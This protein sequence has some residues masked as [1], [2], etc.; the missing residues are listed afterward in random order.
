MKFK[1]RLM[2]ILLSSFLISSLLVSCGNKTNNYNEDIY[3]IYQ[4]AKD[5]G[6]Q[7]TYEEWLESIKGEK[8]E[9]GEKGDKGEIGNPGKDGKN[10]EDGKTPVIA[11]GEN[12][13]WFIDGV[14]T[15]VNANGKQGV[16]GI[17]GKNGT[18]I[19]TGDGLELSAKFGNNGDS[20]INTSTWD[21][22]VKENNNW[23]KVDNIKGSDGK[24]GVDGSDGVSGKDGV[25]GKDGTV[26][27]TGNYDPLDEYGKNG[28]FFLNTYSFDIFL[29]N[30]DKWDKLGNI[31]GSD[32]KDGVDGKDGID[33]KDGNDAETYNISYT[34]TFDALGGKLTN[35]QNVIIAK[36]GETIN[37]PIAEKDN[38]IFKGW[39]TGFGIND[40]KFTNAT[41][42]TSNITLYACWEAI[43]EYTVYFN[44]N[45]G[46]N[47][48]PIN[49]QNN[50]EVDKLPAPTKVDYTFY[51]WYYD[52]GLSNRV[53][54]PFIIEK[55]IE[56]YAKWIDAYYFL[57]FDT[58]GGEIIDNKSF[59]AGTEIIDLPTPSKTYYVFDG[60]YM[61][62]GYS[63][64]VTLPFE[65]HENI[66]IYAK[67]TTTDSVVSFNTN[68]GDNLSDKIVQTGTY[69]LETNM[70]TPIRKNY[71]FDGWYADVSL[72]TKISYPYVVGEDITLYAKWTDNYSGY[73]KISSYS[74][75]CS[76]NKMNGK[77]VLTQ[78]IDCNGYAINQ[79]GSETNPFSGVFD[80]NGYTISNY[81]LNISN[82]VKVDG[83]YLGDYGLFSK[84]NGT[85]INLKIDT[86]LTINCIG[87]INSSF[88]VG[89]I[90]GE[91]TGTISSCGFYG[92]IKATKAQKGGYLH[93]G[94]IVG[95]NTS[96]GF[97]NNCIFGGRLEGGVGDDGIIYS[98]KSQVGGISGSNQGTITLCVNAGSLFS[99]NPYCSG[100][101]TGKQ[102]YVS[103]IANGG[104]INNCLVLISIDGTNI[105]YGSDIGYGSTVSNCYKYENILLVGST[106]QE[107]A[108][109][110]SY[111]KINSKSFYTN[112]LYFNTSIWN[113]NNLDYSCGFYIDLI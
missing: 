54:Y 103:G 6:Y 1:V 5:D 14:D 45:G 107:K 66:T 8:G 96:S 50:I 51:G 57:S 39:Y 55:D 40:G 18:S 52:E 47:L 83:V 65:I 79:I 10:G 25:D 108:T 38:F 15:Q 7:G 89:S 93:V 102:T 13:N 48:E 104:I 80:G 34:I 110:V 100:A 4:L 63:T 58:H 11:I 75:L 26:W 105:S 9:K 61:D 101:V 12:G 20:Y 29:K 106:K 91:N 35:S 22:Y 94:G 99:K 23:K 59:I 21:F 44:T 98:A 95:K 74:Q 37:L 70:P 17:P 3:R 28:D 82:A 77:Y 84:N 87:E 33:G 31:K 73:T 90:V 32:G 71:T 97:I 41:P 53:T 24:D 49:Y 86:V 27:S 92:E 56:V 19:Y 16:M 46:S 2:F 72:K 43:N 76:I 113:V 68:G 69:L 67:W 78:D 60:W 42:I 81:T 112:Q 36:Y 111:S 88:H 64:P 85:I 109:G 30:N 62:S